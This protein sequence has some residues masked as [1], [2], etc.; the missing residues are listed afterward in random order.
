M[1]YEIAKE[2][3]LAAHGAGCTMD[4]PDFRSVSPTDTT[5]Q[6]RLDMRTTLRGKFNADPAPFELFEMVVTSVL[7]ALGGRRL[8]LMLDEFDKV[9]VG[10]QSGVT[11]RN[12]PE[13]FRELIHRHERVSAILTGSQLMKTLRR[14]YFHPIF[15]IGK[16]IPIG[17]LDR[18]SAQLLVTR[19]VQGTLTF[20]DAARDAIVDLC[21]CQ[22]F[23][24]Q[25]LCSAV[26]DI[27]ARGELESITSAHVEQAVSMWLERDQHFAIVLRSDVD[28]PRRQCV[29][30][31][32]AELER[33]G[34]SV[35]FEV[36]R[37]ALEERGLAGD[38]ALT[39]HLQY[40]ADATVVSC[41]GTDDLKVYRITIPLL[42][43]WLARQD[44]ALYLARAQRFDEG[45]L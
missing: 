30:F 38:S 41:E 2:L 10:I 37:D 43:R 42:A 14:E 19:P 17:A 24:I 11:N 26:F 3:I 44:A 5:K 34:V 36:L 25:H 1:F 12:L 28:D 13:N 8:L 35:T 31:V 45:R 9:Q 18:P 22:P 20:S 4:V 39:D 27:A 33:R 29:L 21:G 40:L 15:G 16:A 32:I 6:L 23:L 7:D